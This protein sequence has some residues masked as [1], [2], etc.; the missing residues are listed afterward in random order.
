MSGK[1]NTNVMQ[2]QIKTVQIRKMRDTSLFTVF[3]EHSSQEQCIH[4]LTGT[5]SN[6]FDNLDNL[7][8]S[9]NFRQFDNL[10]SSDSFYQKNIVL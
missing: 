7:D 2:L 1:T 6:L 9:D 5:P 10:D 3:A 4:C 8:S